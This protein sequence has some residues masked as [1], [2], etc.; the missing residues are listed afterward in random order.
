MLDQQRILA[1]RQQTITKAL[2]TALGTIART[3]PKKGTDL[4][5]LG[6]PDLTY[7]RCS[8]HDWVDGFWSGQLWLAYSITQNELFLEAAQAQLPYFADRINRPDSHDHDLGFLY[9]LSCV[10]SFKLT[11]NLEAKALALAAARSLISRYNPKGQFIRAWN[12]WPHDTPE[13]KERKQGKIIIDSME[14]LGLLFWATQMTGDDRF[15]RIAIA[16]ANTVARYIVR[17]DNSSY[18]TFDFDPATGKPVGGFTAQGYADE[19]CWSRGHAWGIHG[20]AQSYA[21]TGQPLFKDNACRLADYAIEHLPD[22]Y[23]P[24][25]DYRL[26]AEAPHYRDSSAGAITSG[27]LF[28][29]AELLEKEGQLEKAQEYSLV[30]WNILAN[31]IQDYTTAEFEQAEGLLLH[32]ASHVTEGYYDNMLPYGDY[33]YLEALLRAK[34]QPQ[35]FFW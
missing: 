29:L 34:G 10:A 12:D 7:M 24:Y 3:I 15:S 28:L 20:F 8:D 22:D 31:L 27:G 14:N 26:P 23:V 35:T 21:Y 18:H 9:S 13:F 4:P 33:F 19:S 6:R 17:P 30:A 25:W 1:N 32:G 11:Q 16:H 2:D 5:K